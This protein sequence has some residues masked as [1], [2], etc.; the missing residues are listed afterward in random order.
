MPRAVV[1]DKPTKQLGLGG[2]T[3][4]HFHNFNH[5]KIDWFSP[6]ILGICKS[7]SEGVSPGK[8]SGKS[9]TFRRG[10]RPD[11]HHGIDHR[12]GKLLRQGGIEFCGERCFC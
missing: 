3:M 6:L 10:R 5:V 12:F 4:L 8:P 11:G 1:E 7:P 2:G 9:R